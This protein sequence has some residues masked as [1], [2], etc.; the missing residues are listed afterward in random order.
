MSAKEQTEQEQIRVISSL[1]EEVRHLKG[2][3]LREAV[4]RERVVQQ[5]S[6]KALL[7]ENRALRTERERLRGAI[8]EFESELTQ[9][10]E[11]EG[12][13]REKG[14]V[15][16]E[17]GRG[18]IVRGEGGRG[19]IVRG[20]G[21]GSMPSVVTVVISAHHQIQQDAH[22]LAK[23]RD[24]FKILYEQV[25]PSAQADCAVLMRDS[26]LSVQAREDL[27]QV[28]SEVASFPSSGQ[29]R[30]VAVER[31]EAVECLR[32]ATAEG[33]RLRERLQLAEESGGEERRTLQQQ[34]EGLRGQIQEVGGAA[35]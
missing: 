18:G 1:R 24:N 31:D 5:G 15:R 12:R 26:S 32:Q 6:S 14:I 34:M 16:G 3:E 27:Q 25:A 13:G 28:R 17:R 2:A 35:G 23:D 30:L 19:G 29:L 11:W 20:E 33:Q 9:V 7:E 8:K 4:R 10:S 21:C 22:D